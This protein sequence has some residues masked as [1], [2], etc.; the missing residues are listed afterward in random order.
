MSGTI[1]PMGLSVN[2][3]W[4]F[5]KSLGRLAGTA[6]ACGMEQPKLRRIKNGWSAHGDGWA[7]HAPTEQEALERFR[8]AEERH[9]AIASRPDP[10][11]P[12]QP[13]EQSR[14]VVRA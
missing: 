2:V 10:I 5:G 13:S 9:A 1:G 12:Q 4:D 11:V 3:P 6:Y 7:V 8:D 14:L